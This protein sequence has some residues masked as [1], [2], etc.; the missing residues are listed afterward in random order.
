MTSVQRIRPAGDVP[1][2][3][4]RRA[5][6]LD[7][8]GRWAARRPAAVLAGWVG[9]LVLAALCAGSFTSRLSAQTNEVRGAES[10]TAARMI[11]QAFPDAPAETDFAVLHSDSLVATDAAFRA[12]VAAL[13]DRYRAAPGVRRVTDPYDEPGTLVAA[14]GHTALVPI[15]VDGDDRRL[16]ELAEPLQGVAASLSTD[17][18]P[19]RLTG[20]S[21]L[22]AATVRQA[23][24]DLGRAERIGLPAA[25]L[26]L[27]IAFG[28]AVAAAIPLTL[29]VAAILTSFGLLGL[30]SYA[31]P[32]STIARSS[33][34]MLAIALGI[35]YSLFIVTR[36]REEIAGVAPADRAG[37]AA[38]V[39]RALG[40]AGRAVLFSGG[41]VVISLAGLFLVRDQ[42]VRTM[43][44]AMMVAVLALLALALS[45]LPAVLGLLGSRVDRL[46][47]PWARRSLRHPDPDRSGWARLA[48]LV[49][50]RPVLVAVGAA[51]LLGA[52]AAPALGLRYGVDNGAGTVADTPAGRGYT[53]VSDSFAPGLVAPISVVVRGERALT[54]AQLEALAGFTDRTAADG[55]VAAAVS[56]TSVLDRR[57]GRHGAGELA[58]ARA[59]APATISALVD[60]AGRT[61]VVTVWPR[62]AAD[63]EPTQALVASVR[64][65]ASTDLA[66]AGLRTAVGGGP[67]QLA[68][69]TAENSRATPRVIAAVLGASWLLL[70]FVFRSV[71][72]PVKAIGM[73]LLSVGA[74]F[75]LVVLVFQHG[76]GAGLLG[77]GRT[78]FIQIMLPLLVFAVSFGLS[79][80][81]EVF[82]LSRMREEWERTG[83][84]AAA[85]RGG[86]THTA[87]VISS[88]AAIMAVVFGA[89]ALTRMV[90]GKQLGFMLA[91]AVLIDATVVRLLLV[92]ALMRLMGRWNWWL[93]GRAD[94]RRA[95]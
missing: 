50:R 46:A 2:A 72:L 58:T 48:T 60:A 80:D 82:M 33:V 94:A 10:G 12:R 47:L 71:L 54:D 9:L 49:M 78:G 18:V 1:S 8:W 6:A 44:L 3:R 52:L 70:L 26:V 31:L 45:L 14:D 61:T 87:R 42:S 21:P 56:V 77:V 53:V 34:T 40:T 55:R 90:E 85:V 43:A 24:R 76:Y 4:P 81:Y 25:A 89:F 51:A 57:T 19:V 17:A 79:M 39:G 65:S 92:P 88:A 59:V 67:A 20:Y 29:G 62:Y 35:D 27:L 95:G 91:A 36:F 93:P 28:S 7:R 86:I 63:A 23:D 11:E 68:E 38:A 5:A 16:R 41:T 32:F 30:L 37:R 13:V 74:A 73:N 75:G 66:G 69:I 64:S 15:G 83:D 22:A 84:N